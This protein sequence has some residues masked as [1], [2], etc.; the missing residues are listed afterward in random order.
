MLVARA[1]STV[2]LALDQDGVW[3]YRGVALVDFED[4]T[5]PCSM[6]T[7]AVRTAI[8]GTVPASGSRCRRSVATGLI[9]R[10]TWLWPRPLGA[11]RVRIAAATGDSC[12][13]ALVLTHQ[14]RRHGPPDHHPE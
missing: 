2:P 11:M 6:G 3:Q 10:E 12:D 9:V 7:K 8:D 1:G 4:R 5:G 13:A 14:R